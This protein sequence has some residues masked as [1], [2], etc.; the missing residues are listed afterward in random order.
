MKSHRHL[1][2][3]RHNRKCAIKLKNAQVLACRH[4]T[5]QPLIYTH[6]SSH[7]HFKTAL[8][9]P[10]TRQTGVSIRSGMSLSFSFLYIHVTLLFHSC[11]LPCCL[12]VS[13]LRAWRRNSTP[14]RVPPKESTYTKA[15]VSKVAF[16]KHFEGETEERVDV[17]ILQQAT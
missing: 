7:L 2:S 17:T 5:P 4:L 12:S 10:L 6:A 14:L 3:I 13:R 1:L 16:A 11:V 8:G 9:T 15:F